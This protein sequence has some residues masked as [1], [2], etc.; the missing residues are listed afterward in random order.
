MANK[1]VRYTIRFTPEDAALLEERAKEQGM[2]ESAYLRLLIRQRPDDHPEIRK[3]LN[4]LIN[5]VNHIGVNINQIVKNHN[6]KFY[7]EAEKVRL[8]AYLRKLILAVNEV[9]RTVGNQ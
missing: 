8:A 2:T 6:A 7:N 5:E 3:S 1:S 9:V 4:A